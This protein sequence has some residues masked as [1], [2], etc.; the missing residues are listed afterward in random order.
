MPIL[1]VDVPPASFDL[2]AKGTAW[3]FEEEPWRTIV[4]SF[5]PHQTSYAVQLREAAAKRKAEGCAF[6]LLFAVKEG[7]MQILDFA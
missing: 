5:A 3:I 4:N 1:A 6:L 7:R 2:M